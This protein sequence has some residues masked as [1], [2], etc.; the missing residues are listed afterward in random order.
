MFVF[1]DIIGHVLWRD[2]DHLIINLFNLFM[3]YI[4][5]IISTLR[6]L[7]ELVLTVN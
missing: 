2:P 6:I 1:N 3:T 4:S 7:E 5:K